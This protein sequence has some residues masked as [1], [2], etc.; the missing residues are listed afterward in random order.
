MRPRLRIG[1]F[2]PAKA[3]HA[4][5]A[6]WRGRERLVDD[7]RLGRI[8]TTLGVMKK[9]VHGI[10]RRDISALP[11]P[12]D[13]IAGR[14]LVRARGRKTGDVRIPREFEHCLPRPTRAR[15]AAASASE[16]SGVVV[17]TEGRPAK[18]AARAASRGYRSSP[19]ASR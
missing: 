16:A 13:L 2:D 18:R 19:G 14:W 12:L 7:P 9:M 1:V 11:R 8:V 4:R 15:A 17:A 6:P 5:T 3:D 10:A